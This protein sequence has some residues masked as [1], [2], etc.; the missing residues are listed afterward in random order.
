LFISKKKINLYT[1]LVKQ[2]DAA[3]QIFK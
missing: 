3:L 1:K 2:I